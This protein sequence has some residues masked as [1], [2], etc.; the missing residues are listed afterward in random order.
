MS[1]SDPKLDISPLYYFIFDT[2]TLL[3]RIQNLWEVT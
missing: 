2:F 3:F 1:N